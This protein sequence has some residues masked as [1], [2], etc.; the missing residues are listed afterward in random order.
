MFKPLL[1]SLAL[2]AASLGVS[3]QTNATAATPTAASATATTITWQ[4]A[5]PTP[6]TSLHTENLMEFAKEVERASEGKLKIS[7]KSDP[8]LKAPAVR[9]AVADGKSPLGELQLAALQPEWQT[10]G[11]DSIPFLA[12]GYPEAQKLYQAQRVALGKKLAAQGLVMLYSVPSP[13][14]GL[15][16]K[17]PVDKLTELRGLSWAAYSPT[18]ERMAKLLGAKPVAVPEAQLTQ[19]VTQGKVDAALASADGFSA[20]AIEGM[21]VFV[22]LRA[23]LPRHAVLMNLKAFEQLDQATRKALVKAAIA[24]EQRGWKQSEARH[25]RFLGALK[26][27]GVAVAP[28]SE[29]LRTGLR[30]TVGEPMLDEWLQRTG[31][32]GK[33][34]IDDY[35]R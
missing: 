13:P 35:R 6:D 25:Q 24:A 28:P 15:F 16:L 20:E 29:A 4:V 34:L 12:S 9:R 30:K 7:L 17:K 2:G 21:E 26:D 3:A 14:P 31:P 19:A 22:D 8:A 1:A 33:L 5:T 11:L 23:W 27:M 32:E 10:F 18:T